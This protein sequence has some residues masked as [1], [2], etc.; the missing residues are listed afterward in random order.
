MMQRVVSDKGTGERASVSNY[1][2]AG[3][4]G[5]VHKFIAGGYAEDRY[6]SIFSGMVPA[7]K[8]ELVMVVMIDEPRNGEHFGG[9]VAAPVFSQVMSGAMRLLDI[10]PDRISKKQLM[11]ADIQTRDISKEGGKV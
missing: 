8:P 3:K 2:V 1:S 6:L 11:N 9:Q 4:T 7:D 10:A 5:T